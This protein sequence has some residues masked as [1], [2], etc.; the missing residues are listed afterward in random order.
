MTI[1]KQPVLVIGGASG[2]GA[3]VTSRLFSLGRPV[4]AAGRNRDKLEAL[5]QSLST[6]SLLSLETVDV[7]DESQTERLFGSIREKF[8]TIS[9]IV[10]GAGSV[11]LKP[12]HLTSVAEFDL[13]FA[14]N[15]R[16]CFLLLKFGVPL[17]DPTGG[18]IVFFSTAAARAGLSNHDV[19]SAAKSAIEGLTR[20]AAATYANKKIRIN[21]IAPGLVK[22]PLTERIHSNPT[23]S[24]ASTSMHALGRLGEPD[25]I[26]SAVTWLL[27]DEATWITGQSIAFDG[28][29]SLK[30]K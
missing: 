12:A 22:T 27:S 17:I 24:Q 8:G 9:G 28:G 23:A 29:L 7:T 1:S 11:L 16:S 4:I 10:N 21:A 19:I 6:P 13:T 2:I 18:S 14:I 15:V 3:A 20:G 5:A 26:A 25:E 30:T